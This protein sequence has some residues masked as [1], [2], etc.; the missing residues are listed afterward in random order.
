VLDDQWAQRAGVRG[1]IIR[2]VA[3]DSP[4]AKAGLRGLARTR[5]GI[6]LGDVIVAVDGTPIATFDDLYGALDGKAP[7]TAVVVTVN[8]DGQAVPVELRLVVVTDG[9]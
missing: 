1:V 5:G 8:R 4:A 3:P 6:R 2:E 9:A 7:G